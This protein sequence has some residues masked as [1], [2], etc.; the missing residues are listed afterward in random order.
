MLRCAKFTNH[1]TGEVEAL[2][3]KFFL[4]FVFRRLQFTIEQTKPEFVE[5][6]PILGKNFATEFVNKHSIVCINEKNNIVGAILSSYLDQEEF[7]YHAFHKRE[8]Y[9]NL[10]I[11]HDMP[12]KKFAL[13]TT[14]LY[15][16]VNLFDKND[17]GKVLYLKHGIVHPDY[18][19]QGILGRML[20]AS[21]DY[22]C[23]DGDLLVF[24]S[25]MERKNIS[26][27]PIINAGYTVLNAV[28]SADFIFRLCV[29]RVKSN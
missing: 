3:E 20:A 5:L 15:K 23:H 8:S 22:F 6:L 21:S 9:L 29:R 25:V 1:H 11:K 16:D 18:R 7:L 19:R 4:P 17:S 2:M 26:D 27:P 10:Q 12:A 28:E 14:A 13:T 24:E